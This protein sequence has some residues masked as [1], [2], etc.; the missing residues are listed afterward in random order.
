M[1][2]IRAARPQSNFYVLDKQ[3][4]EDRRLS[5]SAR[6]LLIFLL[7][8]PDHWQVSVE[9]LLNC[10]PDKKG[11]RKEAIYGYINELIGAGYITR[12]KHASG[13]MDYVVSEF[14]TEIP[15]EKPDWANPDQANPNLGYPTLVSTEIK[16]ELKKAVKTQLE[17]PDW[18]PRENWDG[19]VEMRQRIRKPMTPR[20]A[21]LIIKKLERF[22]QTGQDVGA[23]LDQSVV[24]SWQD[25]FHIRQQYQTQQRVSKQEKAKAFMDVLTGRSDSYDAND[26]F[27]IDAPATRIG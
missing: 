12:K 5:W 13:A 15:E 23:I 6:G 17:L 20:A 24:K 10:G 16:Q 22:M 11:N 25:V 1:G 4:S 9:A 14:P 8:K 27:T 21:S 3:I 7:G 2:I 19:F 26:P 18:I